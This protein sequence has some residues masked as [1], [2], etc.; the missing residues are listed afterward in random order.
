MHSSSPVLRMY[1]LQVSPISITFIT[2]SR[3]LT[4]IV[5]L[6]YDSSTV[7]IDLPLKSQ[8]SGFEPR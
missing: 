1:I 7:L 6:Y 2:S 5:E 4:V 8:H 3:L